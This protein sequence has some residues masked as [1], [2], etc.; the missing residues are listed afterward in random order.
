MTVSSLNKK[1]S[2][3]GL[4]KVNERELA[5]AGVRQARAV[6]QKI[7]EL[8]QSTDLDTIQVG[9]DAIRIFKFP[10]GAGTYFTIPTEELSKLRERSFVSTLLGDVVPRF[11]DETD[12][13]IT[14]NGLPRGVCDSIRI[15]R[16][17]KALLGEPDRDNPA[18]K[19]LIV[20]GRNITF[21]VAKRATGLVWK[22]DRES[23]QFLT[24]LTTAKL[25]SAGVPNIPM[26]SKDEC[27]LMRG[28][29]QTL[30]ISGPRVDGIL[31][32]LP[33]PS[34]TT[35]DVVA[36]L[37]ERTVTFKV[38]VLKGDFKWCIDAKEAP[39]LRHEQLLPAI[40]RLA[41]S[42]V[43]VLPNHNPSKELVVSGPSFKKH[44]GVKGQLLDIW[45]KAAEGLPVS[46]SRTIKFE[47]EQGPQSLEIGYRSLIGQPALVITP[48]SIGLVKSIEALRAIDPTAILPVELYG[49]KAIACSVS[50]LRELGIRHGTEFVERLKGVLG[51]PPHE[52]FSEKQISIEGGAV[53]FFSARCGS[54]FVW[55]VDARDKK[56]FTS[57]QFFKIM[58]PEGHVHFST[59][60]MVALTPQGL[61][62][63]GITIPSSATNDIPRLAEILS[64]PPHQIPIFTASLGSG[65]IPCLMRADLAP[66]Q[67]A[68]KSWSSSLVG[69]ASINQ[70]ERTVHREEL[71]EICPALSRFLDSESKALSQGATR[72]I[73]IPACDLN[74]T[75]IKTHGQNKVGFALKDIDADTLSEHLSEMDPRSEAFKTVHGG[76]GVRIDPDLLRETHG[77]YREI[78][79]AL[80]SR[81]GYDPSSLSAPLAIDLLIETVGTIRLHL[82]H[83]APYD[84]W[85][86]SPTDVDMLTSPALATALGVQNTIPYR[87]PDHIRITRDQ[88]QKRDVPNAKPLAEK[89]HLFLG[90]AGSYVGNIPVDIGPLQAFIVALPS[91]HISW[92]IRQSDKHLL[93]HPTVESILFEG[94]IPPFNERLHIS[95]STPQLT[96]FVHRAEAARQDIL[97]LVSSAPR[98]EN[99]LEE[100]IEINGT[101]FHLPYTMRRSNTVLAIRKEDLPALA[102]AL[103][104]TLREDANNKDFD[105][106]SDLVSALSLLGEDARDVAAYLLLSRGEISAEQ[107]TFMMK[108]V[109]AICR[110]S[111]TSQSVMGLP[112][113]LNRPEV[114]VIEETDAGIPFLKIRGTC[115]GATEIQLTGE[116]SRIFHVSPD[117]TFEGNVP[118]RAARE[119]RLEF[120]A[121]NHNR[122]GRSDLV[123]IDLDLR[124]LVDIL[125]LQDDALLRLLE[126]RGDIVEQIQ[127]SD[128]VSTF[129]RNLL[130][131]QV[132]RKALR[133]FT[134]DEAEGFAYLQSRLEHAPS[135]LSR[136]ILTAVDDE[137]RR[138]QEEEFDEQG[139]KSFFFQRWGA[140]KIREAIRNGE[141]GIML[142]FD[143]GLGKTRTALLAV[144]NEKFLAVVPNGVVSF[145]AAEARDVRPHSTV[146]V[147]AGPYVERDHTLREQADPTSLITNIEYVRQEPSG[148]R[149]SSLSRTICVVDEA[150]FLCNDGTSQSQAI[151]NLESDF[152]LLLTATPFGQYSG[153]GPLLTHLA[154]GL[155]YSRREVSRVFSPDTPEDLVVLHHLLSPHMIYLGKED[156]FDNPPEGQAVRPAHTLPRKTFISPEEAGKFV[157]SD[158]Q[159]RS[160][161]EL[162]AFPEQW[163][164]KHK[165]L[166]TYEDQKSSCYRN[167]YFEVHAAVDQITNDPEYIGS[168]APSPKHAAMRAIIEKEVVGNAAKVVIM[169]RYRKQVE[170]YA[171]MFEEYGVCTIWGE[172]PQNH[173]G[174]KTENGKVCRFATDNDG[175]F[176][177][178]HEGRMIPDMQGGTILAS[179]YELQAFQKRADKRVLIATYDCAAVGITAT[180][181][182]AM[183][184]DQVPP[185]HLILSQAMDRI[186]RLDATFNHIEV[187]YYF[188][189]SQFPDINID[190]L[191]ADLPKEKQDYVRRFLRET[192]C[193]IDRQRIQKNGQIFSHIIHGRPFASDW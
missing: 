152:K 122:S 96:P 71:E 174:E 138:V 148:E 37:E 112:L 165:P 111:R 75:L 25:V 27:A 6:A 115:P 134:K 2:S 104:W 17:L 101:V 97:N 69:I 136:A 83:D 131:R 149:I 137:F 189:V 142:S 88:M 33:A 145:W 179:D 177:L 190:H 156:L 74:L 14:K 38:R 72:E 180:A 80:I 9:N 89:L 175:K 158:E 150:H 118:I 105:T 140:Y 91:G 16:E 70:S 182:Q 108:K 139:T 161:I 84:A 76:Y 129:R 183:V 43:A 30:G 109:R 90:D 23:A 178:D 107:L 163:A 31:S 103:E 144:G 99:T 44:C 173:R 82:P 58:Y 50:S 154:E 160:Q 60:L 172:M 120:M 34:P 187:R 143:P 181:G 13:A 126:R 151:S 22:T 7:V 164:T 98:T 93:Y 5:L 19:R 26:M 157:I 24:S 67:D 53:R 39:L 170:K 8:G 130:T 155:S 132:A 133:H 62:R 47:T 11:N 146:Q 32:L 64:A 188:M 127:G 169:C 110:P 45:R 153:M 42:S 68:F 117:G 193:E 12:V 40:S 135:R 119:I 61:R 166:A 48:P 123:Q 52:H 46:E 56:L 185:S 85:Y 51:E 81:V 28:N 125:E 20:A 176:F 100:R 78:Y 162:I 141:K 95:I 191:V 147:L 15:V 121:F 106:D 18:P 128:P 86:V 29:A 65:T 79:A 116:A 73:S 49:G 3:A 92:A 66:F 167:G 113:V 4:T 10:R 102:E 77:K 35:P 87:E 192:Q 186:H 184:F 54:S 36:P 168:Y 41:D 94:A 55:A 114:E 1:D 57:S 159:L 63:L 171:R 59:K 21:Q 124:H